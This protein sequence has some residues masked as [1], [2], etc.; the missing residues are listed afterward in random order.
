MSVYPLQH[1]ALR[2]TSLVHLKRQRLARKST[3]A[4]HTPDCAL[5]F[6]APPFHQELQFSDAHQ[7]ILLGKK[8]APFFKLKEIFS[9]EVT[10]GGGLKTPAQQGGT[11]FLSARGRFHHDVVASTLKHSSADVE[12]GYALSSWR[13]RHSPKMTFKVKNFV[14][15]K[16]GRHRLPNR[17]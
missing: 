15:L 17:A 5:G 9:L 11:M 12:H 6:L 2:K 13:S 3:F 7:K 16:D 10:L 8:I 1:R 4:S 14:S